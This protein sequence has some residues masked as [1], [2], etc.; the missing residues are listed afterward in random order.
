[1][2]DFYE[3]AV[4]D[5]SF[6]YSMPPPPRARERTRSSVRVCAW[7]SPRFPGTAAAIAASVALFIAVPAAVTATRA[8]PS[9]IVS[10]RDSFKDSP[11]V[12]EALAAKTTR[13]K[14]FLKAVP[15]DE[16]PGWEDPDYGF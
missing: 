3:A 7:A 8:V 14:V 11:R 9:V 10:K 4:Y 5:Q 6:D 16:L 2:S 12:S 15:P 13:A 1:M